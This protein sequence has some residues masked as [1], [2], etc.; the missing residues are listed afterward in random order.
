MHV[1]LQF[2]FNADLLREH[3]REPWMTVYDYQYLDDKIIGGVEKNL[4]AVSEILR[5]VE[6]RATGKVQ[7]Q[8][9]VTS[10]QHQESSGI[11]TE[12]AMSKPGDSMYSHAKDDVLSDGG[13]E[14]REKKMTRF[15]PFNLTKPKPKMIPVPEVIKREVKAR[16][17]PAN[18]N[19]KTLADIEEDKKKR[20]QAT[21]NAIKGEYEGNPKKKFELTTAARP[22]INKFEKVK[23][24]AEHLV[25]K[26][27]QF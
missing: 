20:R 23:Q 14:E 16:P 22:T 10:S 4:P 2:V 17:I 5:N 26:D 12:T 27:L 9:S 8:L 7:S 3:L 6:K 11:L 19:K 25:T 15:E 21:I 13:D 18:M 24:E 1:F